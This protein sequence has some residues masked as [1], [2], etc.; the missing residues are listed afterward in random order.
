MNTFSSKLKKII[1]FV[2]IFII[3]FNINS[4]GVN[5]NNSFN[6]NNTQNI[7]ANQNSQNILNTNVNNINNS[8]NTTKTTTNTTTNNIST[9]NNSTVTNNKKSSNANLSNLGITPN[10]FSGFSE[11]KTSYNV[12]VPYSVK[13]VD[14]YATKKDSKAQLT[15]TGTKV[16]VEGNNVINVVVTAEDG[17]TKTYT[18]NIT[19]LKEGE[20]VTTQNT[21]VNSSFGL[22]ELNIEG[23]N[24]EPNFSTQNYKYT[25]KLDGDISTLNIIASANELNAKVQ[26]IGNENLVNGQNLIT[27][28]VTNS[29][30]TQ[31]ATYQV[32]V[33]KN[34]ISQEELNKQFYELNQKEQKKLWI[35]RILIAIVVIGIIIILII[36]YKKTKSVE[37][38][39][40]DDEEDLPKGVKYKDYT[41][42]VK[43]KTNKKITKKNKGKRAKRYR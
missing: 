37:Q 4:F 7:Q 29:K 18:I 39:E 19:R 35:I 1:F 2:I 6:T 40:E 22:A 14:V 23:L 27:I 12:T 11:N 26:I 28:L 5:V 43:Q 34:I 16:L 8:V 17:T 9:T 38:Y 32:F 41:K 25:V 42:T 30:E 36:R 21:N 20:T 31:V 15:G 24:L 13:Q 10:D 3:I 33:N